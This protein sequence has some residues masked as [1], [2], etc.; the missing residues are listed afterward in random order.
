VT[1]RAATTPLDPSNNESNED[2]KNKYPP[3]PPKKHLSNITEEHLNKGSLHGKNFICYTFELC[4]N[5]SADCT[6][7]CGTS[8]VLNAQIMSHTFC[9]GLLPSDSKKSWL[10]S[11]DHILKRRMQEMQGHDIGH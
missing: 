6:D 1:K 4:L 5:S 11:H 2:D 8:S 9:Q 10:A 3:L 7:S